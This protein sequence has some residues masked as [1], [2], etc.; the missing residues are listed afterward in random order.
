MAEKERDIWEARELFF[1]R[2]FWE[3]I[4]R[5]V[6]RDKVVEIAEKVLRD[7]PEEESIGT[8][9]AALHIASLHLISIG[10]STMPE[11]LKQILKV[12]ERDM[13]GG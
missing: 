5:R 10:L 13:P 7:L 11:T 6:D 3:G 8:L 1:K 2:G 9:L 12:M 4:M